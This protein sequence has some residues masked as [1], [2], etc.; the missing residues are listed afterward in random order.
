MVDPDL[1][2]A[3]VVLAAG[4]SR[5]MGAI[6]KLLAPVQGIPM[7][8]RSVDAL[9][10]AGVSPVVVVTGHMHRDVE[11]ALTGVETAFNARF[12]EGM[13]TSLSVGVSALPD[14]IDGLFVALADM[15][16]VRPA[17]LR[18]MMD[19]FAGAGADCICVPIHGGRRGNPVLFA[20]THREALSR[21]TGDRGA[22]RLVA[23]HQGPTIEVAVDDP[24][25]VRD[26]D[27]P[28]SLAAL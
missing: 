24:G 21:S 12:A 28:E 17:T 7:V 5:R 8:Q 10:L 16:F 22:R 20:T 23:S 13:G 3:G 26:I 14:G 15:P 4:R 6:N 9:L 11:G 27:T 25:V 19:A 1:R 18:T 2:I